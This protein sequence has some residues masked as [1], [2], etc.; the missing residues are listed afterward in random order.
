MESD[1]WIP[2]VP[3]GIKLYKLYEAFIHGQQ[4]S[5]ERDHT[6]KDNTV[7]SFENFQSWWKG[8]R[9]PVQLRYMKQYEL[10][11]E[12]CRKQDLQEMQKYFHATYEK[13]YEDDR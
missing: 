8:L 1:N 12:E 13:I 2:S 5:P 10:G 6:D 11:W 9:T 7:M 4:H 3:V